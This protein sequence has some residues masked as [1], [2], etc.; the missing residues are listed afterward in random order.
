MICSNA[1]YEHAAFPDRQLREGYRC[2]SPGGCHI[3]AMPGLFTYHGVPNDYI[4][5]MPDYF[6]DVCGRIGYS[7][8]H[9]FFKNYSGFYNVAHQMLRGTLVNEFTP[10]S[11]M[12]DLATI[13]QHN[14]FICLSMCRFF[15]DFF[16]G[17]GAN[18]FSSIIC[19]AFKTGKCT[20][21]RNCD[22]RGGGIDGILPILASPVTREHLFRYGNSLVTTGGEEYM[23]RDEIP[24]LI[25][26]SQ[27]FMH[28]SMTL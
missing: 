16:H 4:R 5:L 6:R 22:S 8:V 23:I 20:G 14:F 3:V 15:D 12:R 26:P 7:E 27:S 9:V 1:V 21:K 11:C 19:Y 2:L 28:P 18:L 25:A 10:D 17:E 24:Y 13:L